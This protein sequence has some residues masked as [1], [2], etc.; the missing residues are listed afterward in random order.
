VIPL[1]R[2]TLARLA[3]FASTLVGTAALVLVLLE[4]APG[5]PID[6]LPN[7]AELRPALTAE[8]HL[9][10]PV[11]ERLL[12]WFGRTLSGD[13]G[14]SVAVR[15]GA[16]VT[17]ILAG[18]AL[19][20]F[21]WWA[22]GLVVA[23][24]AGGLL[25]ATGR[26]RIAVRFWSLA[27]VFLLAHLLVAGINA[28]TWAAMEAGWIGRPG[29]FALPDQAG[30]VRT[31]IAIAILAVGSGTLAEVSAEVGDALARLRSAG[32]VDAARAR[33]M[34]VAGHLVRNLVPALAA[35][36][37]RRAAVL[38][39]G[40]IVIE[41]LLLLNGAGTVFWQAAEL[42][43]YDLALG[44]AVGAAAL[45]AGTR[46]AADLVRIAVDPRLSAEVA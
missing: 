32:F 14:T 35:I 9:D 41:R 37:A 18:P 38:L 27:P 39:G 13:L 3:V 43:D 30:L 17:E 42:R 21:G 11:P 2:A 15:P 24:L 12:R 44:A 1:A 7:A 34:P 6:L 22:G 20:T 4:A 23:M 5:D 25:A 33:G 45:V 36:S 46:L 10:R 26:A 28:T 19:R 31:A 29:W 8:W 40:T 16:E